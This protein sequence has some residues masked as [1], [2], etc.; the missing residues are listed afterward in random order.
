MA[1]LQTSG[2][3]SIANIA[4]VMGGAAP[5]SL[6]EYYRGGAFVPSTRTVSTVVREPTS[7]DYY[8]NPGN[9]YGLW[10][11]LSGSSNYFFW[12]G[13]VGITSA[14]S[15]TTGGYTYYRGTYR[16]VVYDKGGA[17]YRYGIYRTSGSTTT[18]NINGSVPTSGAISL[19]NFYGAAKP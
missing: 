18:V 4:S 9:I 16:E 2:A 10:V 19:S 15:I 1:T 5:H 11:L 8:S 13:R 6:S 14:T 3:I 7:G 17:E 12:G